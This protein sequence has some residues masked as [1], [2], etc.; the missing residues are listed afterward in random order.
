MKINA[1]LV[2]E[3]TGKLPRHYAASMRSY[4]DDFDIPDAIK[5]LRSHMKYIDTDTVYYRGDTNKKK[6]NCHVETFMSI[7]KK[8]KH[9]DSFAD[10]DD[11][12]VYTIHIQEDVKG[13]ETGVEGEIILEDGCFWEYFKEDGEHHANI[14]PPDAERGYA[15]CTTSTQKGGRATKK[16]RRG[17]T[18]KRR[19]HLS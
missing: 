9:A 10:A 16:R 7:S 6:N 3:K 4:N 11:S 13:I 18:R 15:Y 8:K 14:Y 5:T 17:S 2:K 12:H 19:Y 1:H